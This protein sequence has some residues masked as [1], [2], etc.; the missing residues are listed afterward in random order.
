MEAAMKITHAPLALSLAICL[1][2][3]QA[4]G[5]AGT[6]AKQAKPPAKHAAPAKPLAWISKADEETLASLERGAWE[7]VKKKGLE[8]IRHAPRS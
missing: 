2:S 6:T 7:A 4:F 5:R 8:S 1:V 3:I